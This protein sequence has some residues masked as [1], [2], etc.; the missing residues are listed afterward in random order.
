MIDE[1]RVS[2]FYQPIS[3]TLEFLKGQGC[4]S[5]GK[6]RSRGSCGDVRHS[7][8]AV[9]VRLGRA[10]DIP[11]PVMPEAVRP[12]R[13]A[14]S[15][16]EARSDHERMPAECRHVR[17]HA[18]RSRSSPACRCWTRSRWFMSRAPGPPRHA[19]PVSDEFGY[20]SRFTDS[21]SSDCARLQARPHGGAVRSPGT[22]TQPS[23]TDRRLHKPPRV[24]AFAE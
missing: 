19:R 6:V 1:A 10:L 21:R 23:D 18:C 3:E 2:T 4:A 14:A 17:S 20:T 13:V 7:H 8:N 9:Q 5:C 24:I 16:A 12:D 15:H 22:P 11:G